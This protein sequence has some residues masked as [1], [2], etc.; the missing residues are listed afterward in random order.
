VDA[1]CRVQLPLGGPRAHGG[2]PSGG[3][4][5]GGDAVNRVVVDASGSSQSPQAK[6]AA[7]ERHMFCLDSDECSGSARPRHVFRVRFAPTPNGTVP[8]RTGGRDLVVRRPNASPR[9][10][11]GRFPID[12]NSNGHR[13]Y[14]AL[15][16]GGCCNRPLPSAHLHPVRPSR[17]Q[18]DGGF[19]GSHRGL[20]D[21]DAMSPT[22]A[23]IPTYLL[24]V[25]MRCIGRHSPRA[26]GYELPTSQVSSANLAL[27]AQAADW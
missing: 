16:G 14:T 10:N 8:Y 21:L 23:T 5:G 24:T 1:R 20:Q 27:S 22:R 9:R 13:T 26:L 2:E 7:A 6:H 15:I 3:G 12:G 17:G 19:R 11:T 4:G 18:V 25:D